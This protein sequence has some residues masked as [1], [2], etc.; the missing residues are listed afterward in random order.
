MVP[1]R[2]SLSGAGSLV[3]ESSALCE[4]TTP[5]TGLVTEQTVQEM[6]ALAPALDLWTAGAQVSPQTRI[7]QGAYG[8]VYRGLWHG[9][10]CAVKLMLAASAE[11]LSSQLTEVFLCKALSCHPNIVQTFDCNVWRITADTLAT[12]QML[13]GG[14]PP[15]GAATSFGAPLGAGG[16]FAAG[17]VPSGSNSALVAGTAYGG[18]PDGASVGAPRHDEVSWPGTSV[19]MSTSYTRQTPSSSKS[20]IAVAKAASSGRHH[21]HQEHG[22]GQDRQEQ[23]GAH[24]AVLA[25]LPVSVEVSKTTLTAQ[26]SGVGAGLES[27]AQCFPALP[28]SS[29]TLASSMMQGSVP[30]LARR[31]STSVGMDSW[32]GMQA[33]TAAA[34]AAVSAAAAAA[35]MAITPLLPDGQVT[36][37]Q[38]E[39][40]HVWRVQPMIGGSGVVDCATSA[41]IPT[42]TTGS[43]VLGCGGSPLHQI[44]TLALQAPS[45][46]RNSRDPVTVSTIVP[47]TLPCADPALLA[48]AAP[49][50]AQLAPLMPLMPAPVPMRQPR[51]HSTKV[52]QVVQPRVAPAPYRTTSSIPTVATAAASDDS[53]PN[54]PRCAFTS[55]AKAPAAA[56][57]SS[58]DSSG[59]RLLSSGSRVRWPAPDGLYGLMPGFSQSRNALGG[60][61]PTAAAAVGLPNAPLSAMQVAMAMAMGMGVGAGVA[62]AASEGRA[63]QGPIS[64]PLSSGQLPSPVWQGS[65]SGLAAGSE[66]ALPAIIGP[67]P[68]LQLRSAVLTGDDG[69]AAMAAAGAHNLAQVLRQLGAREGQLAVVLV[70]EECDRGSLQQL[71]SKAAAA[72]ASVGEAAAAASPAAPAPPGHHPAGTP[73][74]SSGTVGHVIAADSV[75]WQ[76]QQQPRALQGLSGSGP[77]GH[78]QASDARSPGIYVP[79]SGGGRY[80]MQAALR[81]LVLTAKEIALGMAFLHVN[82]IIHGDLKPGNV[83]LKSSRQDQRGF[84]VKIS[85]FG[86]GR[87]L[88]P[89]SPPP[90]SIFAGGALGSPDSE[91]GGADL[92][93]TL[94][95]AGIAD[96]GGGD[97]GGAVQLGALD[98]TVPYLAPELINN[99]QRSKASD[100][101]A[102]GVLLWQLVTG[103]RPYE[104]LLHIQI[105]AAVCSGEQLLTWPPAVH[106][107]LLELG[108]A[109]L[110]FKPQDRPTFAQIVRLLQS[111]EVQMRA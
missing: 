82:N 67:A 22:P 50:L 32:V 73:N 93:P 98:G 45:R 87:V 104:G 24:P 74:L 89:A 66:R 44:R 7:A 81:A 2:L 83:L 64:S 23:A 39:A 110:S 105:M 102:F 79:F 36:S 106:P 96:G 35:V 33:R 38:L 58:H 43:S 76:R 70:M 92:E 65:I 42:T 53:S 8:V 85:D 10:N 46:H 29:T 61:V 47:M 72:A 59:Q 97:G 55:L 80:S 4:V 78:A 31:A 54:T 95:G 91:P 108:R 37:R 18:G 17:F 27:G 51:P 62:T 56:Y 109:C 107:L 20:A 49:P 71:L 48:A 14:G 12:A 19:S 52:A 5:H 60:P 88:H 84:V 99:G 63:G 30:D 1:S 3:I 34:T 9:C 77:N 86:L 111:L 16:A 25:S 103:K 13:C 6:S 11:N 21:H 75:F 57:Y 26:G 15:G 90:R 40:G 41:T 69:D 68:P 101:W 28:T 94:N 100:V